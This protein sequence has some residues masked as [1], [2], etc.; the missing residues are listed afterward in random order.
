MVRDMSF[1]TMLI[2]SL[3]CMCVVDAA[4]AVQS[5]KKRTRLANNLA[6]A[7]LAA[8]GVS[9]SYTI[10]IFMR[11]EHLY[12]IFSSVYFAGIDFAL[13]F[14]L[15]F[16]VELTDTDQATR[17]WRI[18]RMV[19]YAFVAF[20]V[21][22]LL[23]N[24]WLK[25]AILYVPRDTVVSRFSYEMRLLYKC[26]LLLT[27]LFV[28]LILLLLFGKMLQVPKA[29]NRLYRD[30]IYIIVAIVLLNALYLFWPGPVGADYL[31]YSLI[32]Y[33]VAGALL[34][35]N[36]VGGV[37]NKNTQELQ[38][39]I[40]NNVNQG[41]VLFDYTNRLTMCNAMAEKLLQAGSLGQGMTL[42]D[43][44][45]R[46]GLSMDNLTRTGAYAF[47]C[48]VGK[49]DHSLRCDSNVMLDRDKR[50]VSRL[51]VFSDLSTDID[52]LTGFY[53]WS[54]YA[55]TLSTMY[56][57]SD[58]VVAMC[59]INNLSG[60]NNEHGREVGDRVVQQLA[61]E[62]RACF[63]SD[64]CFVRG[65]EAVLAVICTDMTRETAHQL[66]E[67]LMH[68]MENKAFGVSIQSVVYRP[69]LHETLTDALRHAMR[70]LRTKKMLDKKSNRSE[71]L[72]SLIQALH[73]CDNDTEQHVQRTQTAALT[74]GK[75]LGLDD[76]DLNNLALLAV[77]HDI[78]KIGIPLEILNKPGRLAEAEWEVIKTHA[79]KGYQIACS[80]PELESIADMILYHHERWDGKGYPQGLSGEKIP[81]LSRIISV[82][83][84]FD[85]M[86]NDR[87][88]RSRMPVETAKQVLKRNAGT[89][90][91][92]SIV[93]A[94]LSML[95]EMPPIEETRND[96]G[97]SLEE[98]SEIIARQW[99]ASDSLSS[100]H[101]KNVEVVSFC[102]YIIETDTSIAS[103]DEQFETLTGYSFEDVQKNHMMQIDLIPLEDR[104]SYATLVQD[105]VAKSDT[106]FLEHRLQRKD[107]KLLHVYCVG[108]TYYDSAMRKLR[109]RIM[110]T[111]LDKQTVS[112][113]ASGVRSAS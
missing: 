91:D 112:P 83:D 84:A 111:D 19:L 32:G 43:F 63:P 38:A 35:F 58:Y 105:Q 79:E 101:L 21:C 6:Y 36:C 110:V 96:A 99:S 80:S 42:R 90:F 57:S 82:V 24:P 74:L 59:D 10:C 15:R 85:A 4:L 87:S 37:R 18:G 31:D 95:E 47:Q 81:L 78:G 39:W 54:S 26:H 20:D 64:A 13:V 33:S 100:K 56:T 67:Q 104:D 76:E 66:L 5:L 103:V 17:A 44:A 27:Y 11:T 14:L 93:D 71:S 98:Y 34:Y 62:M 92:P 48:Y 2:A 30:A 50:V 108:S 94:Y 86:T 23:L 97:L 69:A 60:I 25:A 77:L 49:K 72:S 9:A 89:Q 109:T 52:I 75:R 12:S 106:V 55:A 7:M 22:V 68:T 88:Y 45:L 102:S 73:E 107:G 46:T 28:A 113:L 65:H 3:C 70:A 40:F 29:Y 61:S 8:V 53:N 16:V 41:I 51:L 1:S